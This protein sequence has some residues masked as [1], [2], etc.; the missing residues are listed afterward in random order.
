MTLKGKKL[1]PNDIQE[2]R[3][4]TMAYKGL[5]IFIVAYKE[6]AKK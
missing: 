3:G 5:V 4:F 1:Y 6:L 2:I